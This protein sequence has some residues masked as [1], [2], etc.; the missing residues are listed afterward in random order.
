MCPFMGMSQLFI[1]QP[2]GMV[3][4]HVVYLIRIQGMYYGCVVV[5]YLYYS[6]ANT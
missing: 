4:I 2:H 3:P 6:V 1:T 5:V